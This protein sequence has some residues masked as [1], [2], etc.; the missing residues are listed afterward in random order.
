MKGLGEIMIVLE[1]KEIM[2]AIWQLN[3]ELL[4][5]VRYSECGFSE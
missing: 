3:Q 2:A 4:S 5:E 1:K